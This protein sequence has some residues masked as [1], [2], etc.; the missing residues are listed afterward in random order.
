MLRRAVAADEDK[1]LINGCNELRLHRPSD[2]HKAMLLSKYSLYLQP[3]TLLC[4]QHMDTEEWTNIIDEAIT[5]ADSFEK[6]HT[7]D[8]VEIFK[9]VLQCIQLT[10]TSALK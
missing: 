4:S 1:C 3:D 5:T 9:S 7:E 8:I 6:E 2:F 10:V